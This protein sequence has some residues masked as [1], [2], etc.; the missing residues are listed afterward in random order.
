GSGLLEGEQE[1]VPFQ[2]IGLARR[3]APFYGLAIADVLLQRVDILLLS[4]VGGER[5]TAIYSA[6]YQLVRVLSKVIQSFWRALYPTLSRLS[7][8][9]RPVATGVALR[10]VQIGL[11]LLLPTVVLM[12]LFA[13][14]LLTLIFGP[15]AAV[16]TPVLQVLLWSTPLYLVESYAT[17]VLMVE[18]K[19][20]QSLWV[21]TLHVVSIVLLLPLFTAQWEATGA[22]LAVVLAGLIST[23][24]SLYVLL[25]NQPR[26]Y[27]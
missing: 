10:G 26:A 4:V 21:S 19:P 17:T 20:S 2:P 9:S 5:V 11:A 12:A 3:L 13:E 8:Q 18:Q 6:A 22:A 16:A 7:H 23:V 14:P 1:A 27:G 24:V 25:R 15:T